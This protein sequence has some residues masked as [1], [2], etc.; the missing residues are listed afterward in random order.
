MRK[1]YY[2]KRFEQSLG[3]SFAGYNNLLVARNMMPRL[4]A[5]GMTAVAAA[6]AM[7]IIYGIYLNRCADGRGGC[8]TAFG[9][10]SGFADQYATMQTKDFYEAA[11]FS[12]R[13]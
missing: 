5:K 2:V 13:V 8:G 7:N 4:R 1:S 12:G 6:A 10:F 3:S 9:G 11:E